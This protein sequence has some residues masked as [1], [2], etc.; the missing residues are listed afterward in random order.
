MVPNSN[1][2]FIGTYTC[3][4]GFEIIPG[5]TYS[6]KTTHDRFYPVAV[7]VT[8]IKTL[9]SQVMCYAS[10]KKFLENWEV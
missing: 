5:E 3:Y 9:E 6:I 10:W 4:S 2:T 7:T 1:L 8:N